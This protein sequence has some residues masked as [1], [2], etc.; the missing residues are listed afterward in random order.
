[1]NNVIESQSPSANEKSPGKNTKSFMIDANSLVSNG[2]V[3]L[4]VT[5]IDKSSE[6]P[7]NREVRLLLEVRYMLLAS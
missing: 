5:A 2:D 4:T 1:M 6:S 3:T 7:K